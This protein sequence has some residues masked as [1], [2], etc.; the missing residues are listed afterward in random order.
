M[1]GENGDDVPRLKWDDVYWTNTHLG[2]LDECDEHHVGELSGT[3]DGDLVVLRV[4]SDDDNRP[5]YTI[6]LTYDQA[7]DLAAMLRMS[8]RS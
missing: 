5:H 3:E 6:R 8:A 1:T 4:G 2:G 7:H